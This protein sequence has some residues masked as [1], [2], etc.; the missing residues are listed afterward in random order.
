MFCLLYGPAHTTICDHWEDHSLDYT[1]LCQQSDVSAFRFVMLLF[2]GT[3]DVVQSSLCNTVDCSLPGF[4]IHGIFQ[5]RVLEW[6]TTAFSSIFPSIR[7]FSIESVLH[8]RWP[9]DW[10]F[11]FSTSPSNEYS[12]LISSR[13]DWLD[14]LAV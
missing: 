10:S 12:G 6:G 8:I 2:Q 11:S 7:V 3:S 5:A 14:L 4:S 1:D 9:N 13:I